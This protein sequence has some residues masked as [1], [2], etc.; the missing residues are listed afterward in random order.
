M[1]YMT[2]Y[3]AVHNNDRID[4]NAQADLDLMTHLLHAD[5]LVSNETRFMRRA[6]TDLWEPRGKIL[7]TSEQFV[8]L[9][10]KL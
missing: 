7:L 9:L 6:F 5:V 2:Y 3:A 10:G 8:G 4:E 1:L